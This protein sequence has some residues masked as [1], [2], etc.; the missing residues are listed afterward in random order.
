M[1]CGQ[2]YRHRGAHPA[3]NE[4]RHPPACVYRPARSPPATYAGDV[5]LSSAELPVVAV[6]ASAAPLTPGPI[7]RVPV[8]NG[9]KAHVR[10]STVATAP[11]RSNSSA[12]AGFASGSLDPSPPP[13]TAAGV[14]PH[15]VVIIADDLGYGNLGYT[16]AASGSHT[17][18]EVH[19]PIIG[20]LVAA[21]IE[22]RRNYV[23]K[24]CS[25]TRCAFQSGRLPV[26]VNLAN[27]D[28]A[29]TN[30]ED[31]VS[32]FAG[33]PRNMTGIA[34]KL[35]EAGYE[36]HQI[37]KW[38]AGMAS[39]GHTPAGRGYDT[40][41][42]YFHHDNDYWTERL[43]STYSD[44]GYSPHCN[45]TIVDLWRAY[46]SLGWGAAGENGT[47]PASSN[48]ARVPP[49]CNGTVE[50]FEEYLFAGVG[51][52]WGSSAGTTTR[53]GPGP[54]G[55]APLPQLR[56][57]HRPR[58]DRAAARVLRGAARADAAQRRG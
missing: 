4:A 51:R 26:H 42:G 48:W 37:G 44:T 13:P 45:A 14:Q 53:P 7:C 11:A 21:G 25:P 43:W 36:T 41:Y 18:A 2:C 24:V 1:S 30:P 16:R 15:I 32:G 33:I 3:S 49:G 27:V 31:P 35:R 20:S 38:G 10:A 23:Y 6:V 5:R 22:L 28:P 19:T 46:G 50:A 12:A 34:T 17:T 58:A 39:H 29:F 57:A 52:R 55:Q 47:A 9:V 8:Q 54:R 40:S 56:P